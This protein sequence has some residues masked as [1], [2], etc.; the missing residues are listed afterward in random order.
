M[1]SCALQNSRG[2]VRPRPAHPGFPISVH[3][4]QGLRTASP[5][6]A[7]EAGACISAEHSSMNATAAPLRGKAAELSVALSSEGSAVEPS[8]GPAWRGSP[9]RPSRRPRTLDPGPA[10]SPI[11]PRVAAVAPVG[12][13]LPARLALRHHAA[14]ICYDIHC[15]RFV[16][17]QISSAP[18]LRSLAAFGHEAFKEGNP[19]HGVGQAAPDSKRT[20]LLKKKRPGGHRQSCR[21]TRRPQ[22]R[23]RLQS[24]EGTC[25]QM[26]TKRGSVAE[27]AQSGVCHGSLTDWRNTQL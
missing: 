27:P 7:T 14:H 15:S 24:Q 16:L 26:L 19:G 12:W 18:N 13:T 3:G 11:Y 9:S 20:G 6:C 2:P 10:L 23:H 5:G 25:T 1:S 4:W 8:E 22:R 21:V 17:S